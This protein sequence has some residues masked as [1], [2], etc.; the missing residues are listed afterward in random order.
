MTRKVLYPVLIWIGMAG[1]AVINGIFRETIIIPRTG[2]QI[3]HIVS[4]VLLIAGIVLVT[5]LFF[6]RVGLDY[7]KNQ[8]V[9]IGVGWCLLTIGFEFV[10]GF[11]EGAP[12]RVVL[13]QYNV[14]SGSIW[15]FVPITLLLVPIVFGSIT[16]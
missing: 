5:Y 10:I 7:S 1:L 9:G 15:V 12:P 8:L 4:T 2:D 6:S 14:L 16:K 13:E 11:L 3:G